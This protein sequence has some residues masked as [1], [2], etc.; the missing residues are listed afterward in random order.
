MILTID[1]EPSVS[2]RRIDSPVG[3]LTLFADEH[4]LLGVY[5]EGHKPAPRVRETLANAHAS[6]LD[7]AARDL[8]AYF[9]D[10]AHRFSV[11]R[12]PRG[13]ELERAVWAVLARIPRGQTRTYGAIATELGR[14]GAARAIGS[15]V[16]RNPLSIVVPCH[17]V[18]GA[19]GALTGFA[20]GLSRKRW[21]LAH[22][23]VELSTSTPSRP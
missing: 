21:L 19:S 14:P 13:T 3:V 9:A 4:A 12:A 7:A 15:A 5:F 20:G 11:R 2:S 10:A 1:H 16:A 18:I 17:R 8:D 6:V 22:E 23:G